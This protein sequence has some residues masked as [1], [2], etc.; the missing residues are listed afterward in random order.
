MRRHTT[1][2]SWQRLGKRLMLMILIPMC[3]FVSIEV[4][5]QV[6]VAAGYNAVQVRLLVRL[7][8]SSL[9]TGKLVSK[10]VV[11]YQRNSLHD[12]GSWSDGFLFQI[13]A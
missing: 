5:E 9:M 12:I 7:T 2:R 3:V 1:N 8:V 13:A 4:Q 6:Q 10:Y 11:L